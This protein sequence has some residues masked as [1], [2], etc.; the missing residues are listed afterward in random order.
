MQNRP[1]TYTIE[2]AKIL[3]DGDLEIVVMPFSAPWLTMLSRVVIFLLLGGVVLAFGKSLA[4]LGMIFVLTALIF[5]ATLPLSIKL[6]FNFL[7]KRMYF[8]ARYLL[9]RPQTL[10]LL[11]P[12]S[13]IVSVDFRAKSKSTVDIQVSDGTK[14]MLHFGVRGHEAQRLV[15]KFAS[16][17]G[18]EAAPMLGAP[19]FVRAADV[20]GTRSLMQRETQSWFIWLLIMGLLQMFTAQGFSSWGALLIAIALASLYFREPAIFVVYAVTIA[21][22]GLSNLLS[23]TTGWNFFSFLQFFFTYRV[24]MQFRRFQK[25]EQ[26]AKTT[27]MDGTPQPPS[28]A[29]RVFP[30]VSIVLGVGSMFGYLLMWAAVLTSAVLGLTSETNSLL[31]GIISALETLTIYGGLLALATG[32]AGWLTGFSY[33]W[34]SIVGTVTGGLTLIISVIVSL[35]LE[36]LSK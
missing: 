18:G 19:E 6:G 29:E 30:W 24:F 36:L 11:V 5:P 7:S 15:N 12:F 16:L 2:S 21:W 4:I 14:F 27:S 1:S 31:W 17:M 25:A 3:S 26:E 10:E 22:A 13:E 32:L 8:E 28:R 34:V 23:G 35:G 9:R 20:A 33:K